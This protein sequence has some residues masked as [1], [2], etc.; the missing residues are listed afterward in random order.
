MAA[1]T[2]TPLDRG[3][4]PHQVRLSRL[5]QKAKKSRAA[6][7][8]KFARAHSAREKFDIAAD[9]MRSITNNPGVEHSQAQDALEQLARLM[10]D[11]TDQLAKTIRRIR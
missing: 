8:I 11:R 3:L 5:Q 6:F 1:D 4:D 2:V 7:V 9:Y 10:I